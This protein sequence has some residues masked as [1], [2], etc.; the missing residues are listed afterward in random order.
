MSENFQAQR[1][2]L[3]SCNMGHLG[4]NSF[5]KNIVPTRLIVVWE[6]YDLRQ[7]LINSYPVQFW[8][9]FHFHFIF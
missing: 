8:E 5:N 9:I 4:H 1:E 3:A 2:I 7:T 6:P